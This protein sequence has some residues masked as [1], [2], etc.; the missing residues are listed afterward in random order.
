[1]DGGVFWAAVAQE[2]APAA[3]RMVSDSSTAGARRLVMDHS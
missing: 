1:V 2:E 3:A